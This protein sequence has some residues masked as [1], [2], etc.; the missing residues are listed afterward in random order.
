MRLIAAG[1]SELI[2]G[3]SHHART[4]IAHEVVERSCS[5][6]SA[7]SLSAD[8]ASA[9]IKGP[10]VSPRTANAHKVLDS[11]C[12]KNAVILAREAAD[13]EAIRG[14]SSTFNTDQDHKVMAKCTVQ[15][16]KTISMTF[17]RLGNDSR[18]PHRPNTES[19]HSKLAMLC[20]SLLS[21]ALKANSLHADTSPDL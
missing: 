4:D 21:F 6:N 12:G 5:A 19:P 18:H 17:K 20:M 11:P 10:L 2:S 1:E 8:A 7:R 16:D 14:T 15:N 3:S 13:I 9:D